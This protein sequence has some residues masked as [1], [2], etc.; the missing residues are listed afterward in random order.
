ME[1]ELG[2]CGKGSGHVRVL[3]KAGQCR[4]RGNP[5][6][7]NLCSEL[8]AERMEEAVILGVT[9]IQRLGI[10]RCKPALYIFVQMRVNADSR[11][12]PRVS[13]KTNLVIHN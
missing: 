4:G 9:L 10:P 3:M 6:G 2:L 11:P 13:Y 7:L 1:E 8:F 12:S 5:P